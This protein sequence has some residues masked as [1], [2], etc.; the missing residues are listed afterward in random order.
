MSFVARIFLKI[1]FFPLTRILLAVFAIA[2][3]FGLELAAQQKIGEAYVLKGQAWYVVLSSTIMI[4]SVCLV[5]AGYVRLFE[6]RPTVELSKKN[7]LREFSKGA[8]IGFGLFAA[9]I[10]CLWVGGY[11]RVQGIGRVPSAGTLMGLGFVAAFL[12]EIIVRG[13]IFR[14][15]RGI[16]RHLARGG[17]LRGLLR[18][19]PH[20]QSGSELARRT[21]H[22]RGSGNPFG[23]GFYHNPP[24]LA[25]DRAALRLELH[26]GR[27]LRRPRFGWESSRNPRVIAHG[28]GTAFR[29]QVRRG[30]IN[31]RSSR[32]HLDGHLLDGSRRPERSNHP[33]VLVKEP[34]ETEYR[35]RRRTE[36]CESIIVTCTDCLPSLLEL[37][38]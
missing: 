5:Y 38:S 4:V 1:L 8:A 19:Y 10:A 17:D 31:F 11:Y 36:H 2:L 6:R 29:R 20:P 22:R 14:N 3:V 25:P 16:A 15:H 24:A 12:E 33:A 21:V 32:L 34:D 23:G 30:G 37:K 13:V 35:N 9:T 7:A 28:S 27:N 18:S 26:P